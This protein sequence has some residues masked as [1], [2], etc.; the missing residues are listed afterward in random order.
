MCREIDQG[1][2]DAAARAA[3]APF[4]GEGAKAARDPYRCNTDLQ[5]MM[6]DM[7]GIVRRESEM[8]QASNI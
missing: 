7:V 4:E 5:E 6:Q 2:V 8:A 3:L 1:E